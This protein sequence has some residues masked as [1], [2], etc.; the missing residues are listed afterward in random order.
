MTK[1]RQLIIQKTIVRRMHQ[2]KVCNIVEIFPVKPQRMSLYHAAFVTVKKDTFTVIQRYTCISIIP[3]VGPAAR[4]WNTISLQRLFDTSCNE[5]GSKYAEKFTFCTKHFGI[6]RN[7]QRLSTG[8]HPL[9][10]NINVADI[11]SD[12]E[13][14]HV[15]TPSSRTCASNGS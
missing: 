12:S 4:K 11:I 9:L 3:G 10:M 15:F 5:V 6:H 13:H 1:F 8:I 2:E 7:I 14:F